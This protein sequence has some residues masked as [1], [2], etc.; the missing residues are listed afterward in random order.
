MASHYTNGSTGYKGIERRK[1][2]RRNVADRRKDIRW[3]PNNPNRR[4][5][6]GRRASDQLGVHK[7]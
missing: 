3:E 1:F 4:Q 7:R 5:S 6:T 2:N